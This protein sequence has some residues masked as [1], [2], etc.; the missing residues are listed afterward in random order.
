MKHFTWKKVL[1]LFLLLP[2]ALLNLSLFIPE[3]NFLFEPS[4]TNKKGKIYSYTFTKGQK[5][6]YNV[7][8][9]EEGD[10]KKIHFLGPWTQ[11]VKGSRPKG[12]LIDHK[13]T[14]KRASSLP[15][16]APYKDYSF[17][18]LQTSHG[19][20]LEIYFDLDP[21]KKPLSSKDK[22]WIKKFL[23]TSL[24]IFSET[25]KE[26]GDSWSPKKVIPSIFKTKEIE[27][28]KIQGFKMGIF[29]TI[30]KK[31]KRI[32]ESNII[33]DTNSSR[34]YSL[35]V[36]KMGPLQLDQTILKIKLNH[37]SKI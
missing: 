3:K 35:Y 34:I 20:I 24:L 37:L 11:I 19:N 15:K 17:R 25:P 13:I 6:L 21:I 16:E 8:W 30:K 18:T 7:E 1:L 23:Q 28:F 12:H 2:L 29:S 4:K 22:I 32:K 33:F 26:L 9:K 10:H 31:S 36:K 27:H 14:L 5:V